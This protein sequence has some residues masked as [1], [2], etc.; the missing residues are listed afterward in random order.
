MEPARKVLLHQQCVRAYAAAGP[1][2]CHPIQP[3]EVEFRKRTVRGALRLPDSPSPHP[4]VVL[5]NGTNGVKEELHPGRT[6]SSSAASPRSR[7]T[8]PGW[9]RRSTGW[10]ASPSRGRSAWR[11]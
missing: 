5:F 7:W 11:S 1:L 3:F 8:A 6:R 9:A 2:L 4:V 10:V